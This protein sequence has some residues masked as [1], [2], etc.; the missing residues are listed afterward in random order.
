MGYVA[1]QACNAPFTYHIDLHHEN[2]Q[3]TREMDEVTFH[4]RLEGPHKTHLADEDFP[5][6]HKRVSIIWGDG[7]GKPKIIETTFTAS[8]A[9]EGK[10]PSIV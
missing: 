7:A 3:T 2:T 9:V 8:P 5:R 6:L 4:C 1:S 10:V